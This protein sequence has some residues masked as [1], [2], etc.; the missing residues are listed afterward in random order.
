MTATA[1]TVG[2]TTFST[3]SD[4]EIVMTRV[5]DAP[6]KL[7]FDAWTNPEHL[8]RWFGRRGWTL[9]ICEVDLR[10]GGAWRF[11]L[12]GPNGRSMGMH[13]VYHEIAPPDRLV[14]S[15]A[16]DGYEGETINT[17]VLTEQDGKTTITCTSR[18]PS[19]AARD[20]MLRTNMMIGAASSLDRL[21][22]FIA[23]QSRRG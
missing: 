13:G 11:A 10:P 20:A 9:P 18:Y 2:A 6:R 21:S 4:D 15:E 7:V 22:A 19:K 1:H 5:Y 12:S 16:L 3:P 17:L 23:E 8:P 14:Y